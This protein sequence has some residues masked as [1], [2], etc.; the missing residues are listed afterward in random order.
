MVVLRESLYPSQ[1]EDAAEL[2]GSLDWRGHPEAVD[3]LVDRARQD[4]AP[5]VRAECVR[6]LGRMRANT[7][8]VVEVVKA[9]QSD[10][11]PYVR[12]EADD[13]YAALTGAA[14]KAAGAA[15][16]APSN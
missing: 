14:P 5:T 4:P 1:R 10:E 15:G 9:L 13:A 12:H 7:L 6:S 16:A 2:L 3:L 8:P 11:D